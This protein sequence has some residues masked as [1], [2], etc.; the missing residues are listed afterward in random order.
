MPGPQGVR[1]ERADIYRLRQL[2][3]E[4]VYFHRKAIDNSRV[5]R[6][7]DPEGRAQCWWL[8]AATCLTTLLLI[9]GL[10]PQVHGVLAGYQIES[11]KQEQQRLVADRAALQLQEETLLSPERLEELARMQEFIDPAPGQVVYLNPKPDGSLALNVP[12]KQEGKT[13]FHDSEA[14]N[15]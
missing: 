6:Q 5:E 7:V 3:N 10:W 2:P 8:I 11:L 13:S 1:S 14:H 4:D 15:Q 12:A 9:A